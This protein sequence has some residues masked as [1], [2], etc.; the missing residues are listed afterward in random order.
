MLFKVKNNDS[1]YSCAISCLQWI[2]TSIAFSARLEVFKCPERKNMK[3]K[4]SKKEES[5]VKRWRHWFIC[6]KVM[7][8]NPKNR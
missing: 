6:N 5:S 3:K 2:V 4:E 7:S 8:K 1:Q